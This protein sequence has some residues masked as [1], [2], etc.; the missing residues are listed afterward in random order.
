MRRIMTPQRVAHRIDMP[1]MGVSQ[2]DTPSA[3]A[4][5]LDTIR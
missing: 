1:D 4:T 2:L 5:Y 3:I